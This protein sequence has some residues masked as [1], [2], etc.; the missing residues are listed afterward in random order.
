MS[1]ST[2]ISRINTD[3]QTIRSKLVELGMATSTDNLDT[4]AT[5]VSNITNRGSVSATVK[6]GQTYTIPAGYHNGS[7]TVTGVGGG[8]DYSLQSKTVRPTKT[9]V[10]VTPDSGYYGLS[11]VTVEPIP[12]N[13]QDISG[14]TATAADVLATKTFVTAAGV[15]T[16][17]TMTNNGAISRTI[18]G[19]TSMS[20]TIPAGYH[21][22]SGKVTLTGDIEA[23]LAEI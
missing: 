6:E 8:G 13:Y 16:A 9:S 7:G 23:A 11:D 1:I 4:L 17:G 19:L 12:D 10:P 18:D 2:Q 3:K 5:A 21:N 14:T 22:G 20:V 15:S